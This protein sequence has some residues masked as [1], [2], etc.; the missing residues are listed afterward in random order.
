MLKGVINKIELHRILPTL[1]RYMSLLQQKDPELFNLIELEK[2]RQK[3]GLEM[4]ASENFTSPQ[5]MECLGSILTNKYSEGMP[6]KRY[7]GGN[8]YIDKIETLCIERALKAFHL[9]PEVWGVNVQ[10]VSGSPANLAAYNALLSPHDR[11]MGLDLP[12]GGHLTHGFYTAKKKISA[13]SIFYESLPYYVGDDGYIDYDDLEKTAS[14][15]LPKLIVCGAS[16][17]PRDLDYPRFRKIADQVGAYLMCDMAHISGLI[18]TQEHNNPFDYCDIV[19]STTHKTLRGPRSGLIFAKRQYMDAVNFSVFPTLSGG[20]H[21]HQ[22]AGVATQL[23]EVQTP[24]FKE[25]IKQVKLNAKTLASELTG[26]GYTLIS[27]GTDN[28]LVMVDLKPLNLT[29]SKA[30]KMLET[31][32]ISVNKNATKGD[33]S[34]LTPMGIRIGV[35]ALTTRKMKE[36]DFKQVTEYIHRALQLA[37]KIQNISGKK[38]ADFA[39]IAEE[40]QEVKMLAIEIKAY[41]LNWPMP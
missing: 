10:P 7:Y 32:G 29:G 26:Y 37:L 20:P 21:N 1:R 13:S 41:A 6:G 35:N 25:Y 22:I 39:R 12:S 2:T 23:L 14:R 8:Q 15:F 28:H 18:A 4:I 27:G 33:K 30:E 5:V 34:A 36:N 3:E 24:E 31:V 9:D 11:I 40:D 19:T 16:A 38:L 17:Y